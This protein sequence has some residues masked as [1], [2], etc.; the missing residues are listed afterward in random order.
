MKSVVPLIVLALLC[1][2]A[3]F[4]GH[5]L[6]EKEGTQ[7]VMPGA[8]EQNIPDIGSI[9]ILNGCGKAGLADKV[10]DYLR[11]HRF[12]VKNTANA[13]TWNYKKSMVI[14]R[15]PDLTI[16]RK[17]AMVLHCP[18]PILLRTEQT[19]YD[20]TVIIGHNYKEIPYE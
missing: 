6:R 15:I 5:S 4:L 13:D 19:A 10:A 17:V 1:G 7:T 12:D 9:E 14:S 8:P 18:E 16:A 2:S 3:I 11:A 20:V